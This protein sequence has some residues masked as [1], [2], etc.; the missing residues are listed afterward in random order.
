MFMNIYEWICTDFEW[1]AAWKRVAA[2]IAF[3]FGSSIPIALVATEG[4]DVSIDASEG[5]GESKISSS[6]THGV[7]VLEVCQFELQTGMWWKPNFTCI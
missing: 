3:D 1:A 7:L 4:Q 2:I 5:D 6:E